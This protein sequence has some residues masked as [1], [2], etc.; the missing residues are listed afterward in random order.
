MKWEGHAPERWEYAPSLFAQ[1]QV[2]ARRR[3]KD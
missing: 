3:E 2:E 1:V